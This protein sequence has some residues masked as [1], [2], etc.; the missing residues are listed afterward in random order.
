MHCVVCD[1]LQDACMPHS[2]AAAAARTLPPALCGACSAIRE[3]QVGVSL[4]SL[5]NVANFVS[6]GEHWQAARGGAAL[7][8]YAARQTAAAPQRDWRLLWRRHV[9]V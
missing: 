5:G 7:V 3:W 6:F 2:P 8:Q 9:S 1:R 4:F